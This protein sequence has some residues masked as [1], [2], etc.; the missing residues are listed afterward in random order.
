[1]DIAG[2]II[3]TSIN[4]DI[5][6]PISVYVPIVAVPDRVLQDVRVA[7]KRNLDDARTFT[8]SW[9]TARIRT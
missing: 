4:V 6:T 5:V 2:S 1:M 7:G 9:G 8:E 3:I